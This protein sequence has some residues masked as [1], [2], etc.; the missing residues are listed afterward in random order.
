LGFTDKGSFC[1]EGSVWLEFEGVGA[2]V[3]HPPATFGKWIEQG[4]KV[5]AYEPTK[6]PTVTEVVFTFGVESKE[7]VFSLVDAAVAAGGKHG[8]MMVPEEEQKKHGMTSRSV[9]DPE[10]HLF[11]I[12]YMD[13]SQMGAAEC[14]GSSQAAS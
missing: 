14:P 6:E 5:H 11:E 12:I 4:S 10:G 13:E 3:Y 8:P 9:V 1:G 2:I 7:D